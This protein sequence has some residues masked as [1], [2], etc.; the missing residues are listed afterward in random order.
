MAA[1]TWKRLAHKILPAHKD[2]L[3]SI[4]DPESIK[5]YWIDRALYFFLITA[6]IYT[7]I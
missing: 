6:L 5:T 7:Q 2:V 3:R 4:D 1:L